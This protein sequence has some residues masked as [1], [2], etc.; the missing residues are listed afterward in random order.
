MCYLPSYLPT[1]LPTVPP[2]PVPS[3]PTYLPTYLSFFLHTLPRTGENPSRPGEPWSVVLRT[4]DSHHI[5]CG[6]VPGKRGCARKRER[7]LRLPGRLVTAMVLWP[8][9]S[10]PTCC[11]W[12]LSTWIPCLPRTGENPSHPGEPWS[13]LLRTSVCHHIVCGSVPVER[14]CVRK[15]ARPCAL[16]RWTHGCFGVFT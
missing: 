5:L 10:S 11:A 13:D 14:G 1:Y 8:A 12:G 2:P 9:P 4:S 3:L 7:P 15:R 6:S 16:Y